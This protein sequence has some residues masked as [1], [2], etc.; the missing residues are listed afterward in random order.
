MANF[1][2][3]DPANYRV[4]SL[5]NVMY[6]MFSSILNSRLC[7]WAEM[8]NKIDEAQAG[9]KVGYSCTDTMFTLQS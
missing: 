9:F 8:Y 4:I 6:K 5:V 1:Q 3:N 7:K 2:K